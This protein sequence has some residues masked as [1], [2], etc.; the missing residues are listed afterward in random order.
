MKKAKEWGV[1]TVSVQWLN[2]VLFGGVTG[3]PH[4]ALIVDLREVVAVILLVG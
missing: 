2:E 4:L 1:P 3:Q